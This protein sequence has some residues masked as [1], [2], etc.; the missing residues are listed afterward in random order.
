MFCAFNCNFCARFLSLPLTELEKSNSPPNNFAGSGKD[1]SSGIGG[2]LSKFKLRPESESIA[3]EKQD[4]KF[5]N[6]LG[7]EEGKDVCE[8]NA[9][10]QSK[11]EMK[12]RRINVEDLGK[13][14]IVSCISA[15]L[16]NE[17]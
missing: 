14:T 2:R 8:R 17:Y 7:I 11:K 1:T 9:S 12:A 5:L 15:V 6:W 3:A 13:Q 4:M 16:C 10:D